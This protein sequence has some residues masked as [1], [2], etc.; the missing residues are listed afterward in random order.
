MRAMPTVPLVLHELPVERDTIEQMRSDA[1]RKYW[2][3]RRFR[4]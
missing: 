2:G 4:P 1:R 3:E